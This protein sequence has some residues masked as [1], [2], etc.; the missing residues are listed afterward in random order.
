MSAN[1]DQTH[2]AL[3]RLWGPPA[4]SLSN[5]RPSGVAHKSGRWSVAWPGSLFHWALSA[6]GGEESSSVAESLHCRERGGVWGCRSRAIAGLCWTSR[7]SPHSEATLPQLSPTGALP[8]I[9]GYRSGQPQVRLGL[10]EGGT[11]GAWW[12]QR[13]HL[14]S[15]CLGRTSSLLWPTGRLDWSQAL[16][17]IPW[18]LVASRRAGNG[19]WPGREEGP[20]SAGLCQVQAGGRAE[21]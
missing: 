14:R 9:C 3:Q 4:P 7:V 5:S 18:G 2:G 19:L 8:G 17:R 16:P 20:G 12:P 21:G 13:P 11:P 1:W 6:W 15:G 10:G